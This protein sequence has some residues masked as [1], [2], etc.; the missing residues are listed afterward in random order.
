MVCIID[1]CRG[2]YHCYTPKLMSLIQAMVCTIDTDQSL[3][4]LNM[5]GLVSLVQ[6][7]MP[8][9]I[10][11]IICIIA[12]TLDCIL[13]VPLLV[14]M[15]PDMVSWFVSLIQDSYTIA[16]LYVY[17]WYSLWLVSLIQVMICIIDTDVSCYHWYIPWCVSSM[18]TSASVIDTGSPL[19]FLSYLIPLRY[20][21]LLWQCGGWCSHL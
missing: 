4:H 19:P 12:K 5:S 18:Q 2:K 17:H 3:C 15:I 21:F 20:R 14:S 10:S 13:D 11:L 6:V 1:T 16:T 7:Q 9:F 8:W